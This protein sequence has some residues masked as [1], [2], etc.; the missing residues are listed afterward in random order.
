MVLKMI[1][2]KQE[3]LILVCRFPPLGTKIP[4]AVQTYM[5]SVMDAG[6]VLVAGLFGNTGP[7]LQNLFVDRGS[8]TAIHQ[9]W[10]MGDTDAV[11]TYPAYWVILANHRLEDANSTRALKVN[12]CFPEGRFERRP[13]ERALLPVQECVPE[14]TS[15]VDVPG[16]RAKWWSCPKNVG[17]VKAITPAFEWWTFGIYQLP[18]WL[19]GSP[20]R[21]KASPARK[22]RQ[23]AFCDMELK[24]ALR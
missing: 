8:G 19:E 15:W 10:L 12:G 3:W 20:T 6:A 23:R 16:S 9:G 14:W 24:A 5:T 21:K 22:A 13:F 1:A 11:C 17:A 18:L 7:Q 4:Q 2:F